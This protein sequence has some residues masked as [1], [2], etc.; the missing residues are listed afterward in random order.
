MRAGKELQTAGPL[1]TP[2]HT[3]YVG[4][5]CA[6]KGSGGAITAAHLTIRRGVSKLI[7]RRVPAGA[8]SGRSAGPRSPRDERLSPPERAG[9]HRAVR[10]PRNPDKSESLLARRTRRLL[11]AGE[12]VAYIRGGDKSP[13]SR[14]LICRGGASQTLRTAH[15]ASALRSGAAPG[16]YA[17]A[18]GRSDSPDK[19]AR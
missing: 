8:R 14:R 7:G 12:A 15:L 6:G 19:L 4:P 18:S 13:V 5:R 1:T 16:T 9:G 3:S 17:T 11:P 10:S 2:A